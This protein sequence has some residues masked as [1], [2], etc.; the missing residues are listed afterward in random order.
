MRKFVSGCLE[1]TN[2]SVPHQNEVALIQL[3]R[4][5]KAEKY[6]KIKM[7]RMSAEEVCLFGFPVHREEAWAKRT[8]VKG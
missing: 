4:R 5:L 2:P 6:F 1:N 3:D 8:I 7:I